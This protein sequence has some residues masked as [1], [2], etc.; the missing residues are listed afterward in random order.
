MP[1]VSAYEMVEVEDALAAILDR[2]SPLGT[3]MVPLTAARGRFLA[4][5]VLADADLPGLPRSSVDGYAVIA[6]DA[7]TDLQVLGEV[8]AG[9]LGDARVR[10]GSAMRIMTGGS[11]PEGT[12]AVVMFEDVEEV[13]GRAILQHKPRQGENVHPVGMDLTAGQAVLSKGRRIGPAEVGLLATVGCV[14]VPVF[15]LPRV[16]MLATG[17]ELVDPDQA[18]APGAVRDSNRFAVMAAAQD[19]GAEIVFQAH[20]RDDEATLERA[21]RSGLEAADVLITSGGVSMGT[22]DLIKPLLERMATIQFGRVSFKPGKPLTFAVTA[23]GKLCFGLPGFPVSSLITFEVFVRPALLKLAGAEQVLRPRIEVFLGHDI[24]PDPVRPEYQ[25]ATVSWEDHHFVA[26]T[27]G[28]QASS[29]LMSIVG[30]NALLE[31]DPGTE[32]LAK[33][34]M[35][36]ALLLANL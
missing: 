1:R 20:A 3:E 13:D 27:T 19:A 23:E 15:R 29:R 12:D 32:T 28:L 4:E 16:A 31:I 22:R 24:R 11:L 36:Q 2:A 6:S 8:T 26:R 9:R 18:P 21:M 7:A 14:H 25:R 30:A 35:V 34:T 17:D 5:D 33:G 10:P